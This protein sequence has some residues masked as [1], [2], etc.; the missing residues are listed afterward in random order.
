MNNFRLIIRKDSNE[1]ATWELWDN[2]VSI[3]PQHG[4]FTEDG[5]KKCTV[6]RAVNAAKLTAKRL[7]G[8]ITK[9]TYKEQGHSQELKI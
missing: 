4:K 3:K 9:A 5:S 7:N 6:E 2:G 1:E 8:V